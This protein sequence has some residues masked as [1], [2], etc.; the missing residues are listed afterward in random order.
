MIS[1]L[2]FPFLFCAGAAALAQAP[3]T[4]E[5]RVDS[6]GGGEAVITNLKGVP[7]TAYL[8]QVFLE[9]C[10]PTPRPAVFRAADV[11][12]TPGGEP[13][14][15]FQSHTEP[16]GS[17]YCNKDGV[18]VPARAELKAAIYQDGSSFGEPQWVNSLLDSR[19]FQLEQFEIVLN[20]L[21]ARDAGSGPRQVLTADLEEGLAAAQEKKTFPFPCLLDVREL[22][23][24]EFKAGA[25][26]S[27]PDQIARTIKL[28][29]Q[30]RNKLLDARPSLR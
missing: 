5:S 29:E 11:A 6:R 15:Q 8:L 22:A 1:H 24:E 30:L 21:K 27:L 13:L 23:F 14:P 9:P 25:G 16:L 12:L 3:V 19:K 18:S 7:L 28:F 26:A 4:L 10:S 17:A 2:C 20:G